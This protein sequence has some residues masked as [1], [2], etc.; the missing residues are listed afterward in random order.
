MV[1]TV[2]RTIVEN[3]KNLM[4]ESGITQIRQVEL[5]DVIFENPFTNELRGDELLTNTRRQVHNAY[6]SRVFPYSYGSSKTLAVSE[7]FVDFLA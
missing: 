6:Y 4:E 2:L 1:T 3:L 7:E 5:E